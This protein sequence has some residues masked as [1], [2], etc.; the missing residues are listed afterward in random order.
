MWMRKLKRWLIDRVLPVWA[1]E[2]L[3]KEIDRLK[4]ENERLRQVVALKDE[5]IDGMKWCVR[6]LRR[7]VVEEGKR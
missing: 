7:A 3:L 1:R 5:Y 6:A 2:Q 4:D